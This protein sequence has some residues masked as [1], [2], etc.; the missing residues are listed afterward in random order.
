MVEQAKVFLSKMSEKINNGEFD[1]ALTIPFIS[2]ELI[3]SS[4]LARI[5]KKIETKATPLL[6]DTEV[7]DAINDAREIA[8][9][10]ALIF[11]HNGMLEIKDGE[12]VLT[13]KGHMY[14]KL[15]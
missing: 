13:E 15:S 11:F 10:T 7:K 4:V 6:N 5:E 14:V 3:Y 9:H 1:Y 8:A 12:F 2:R